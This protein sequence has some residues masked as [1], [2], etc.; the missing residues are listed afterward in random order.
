[1]KLFEQLVVFTVSDELAA[2][3]VISAIVPADFVGKLRVAG[4]GLVKRHSGNS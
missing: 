4:F 3:D 2:F 1:L